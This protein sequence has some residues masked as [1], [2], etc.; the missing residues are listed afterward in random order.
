M[1]LPS[2]PGDDIVESAGDGVVRMTW[3]RRDVDV[4]SCWRLCCRVMLAIVLPRHAGD[5]D[6]AAGAIWLW[7]DVDVE[8]C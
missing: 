5:G 7:R 8:S 6:G 2:H 4:E 3:P 1:S